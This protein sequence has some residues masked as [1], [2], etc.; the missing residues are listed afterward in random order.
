MKTQ[1]AWVLMIF[2]GG[3]YSSQIAATGPSYVTDLMIF[4]I[5]KYENPDPHTQAARGPIVMRAYAAL[6]S[7]ATALIMTSY[8]LALVMKLY[9]KAPLS[10]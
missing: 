10:F 3:G 7:S 6:S 1:L 4:F 2:L 9:P 5:D 8:V